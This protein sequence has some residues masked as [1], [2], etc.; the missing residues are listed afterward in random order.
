MVK[1][2]EE[3]PSLTNIIIACII[4]FFIFGFFGTITCKDGYGY[5]IGQFGDRETDSWLDLSEVILLFLAAI[6][7]VLGWK[8]IAE[9]KVLYAVF[10]LVVGVVGGIVGSTMCV[11]NESWF[12]HSGSGG[13]RGWIKSW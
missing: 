12:T 3:L 2:I 1:L 4:V 13:M 11:K 10:F 8:K 9:F 7:F 5:F 6:L